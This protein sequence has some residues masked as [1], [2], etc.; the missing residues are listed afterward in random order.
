MAVLANV[1]YHRLERLSVH[2][3]IMSVD[4]VNALITAQIIE[5]LLQ[6]KPKLLTKGTNKY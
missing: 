4:K 6:G 5:C 1:I 2:I 3:A